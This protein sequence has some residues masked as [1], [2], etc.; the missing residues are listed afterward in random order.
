MYYSVKL[1]WYVV[2]YRTVLLATNNKYFINAL[3][4]TTRGSEIVILSVCPS[5]TRVLCC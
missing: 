1:N 5:V 4:F 2:G 3:R